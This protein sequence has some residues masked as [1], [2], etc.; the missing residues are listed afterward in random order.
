MNIFKSNMSVETAEKIDEGI[1][2]LKCIE[3]GA[4]HG[5][6]GACKVEWVNED[7]KLTPYCGDCCAKE[8]FL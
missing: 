5:W 7:L 4:P 6:G 3:C 8:S 2:A 1:K